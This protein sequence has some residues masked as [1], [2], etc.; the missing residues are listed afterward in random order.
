MYVTTIPKW[1]LC[2]S[3]VEQTWGFELIDGQRRHVRRLVL[4]SSG[5]KDGPLR[6]RLVYNYCE[7]SSAVIK[8]YVG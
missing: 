1:K 4:N 8:V 3:F 7:K 2:Q 6:V 5:K